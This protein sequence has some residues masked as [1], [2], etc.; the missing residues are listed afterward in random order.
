MDA[1]MDDLRVDF[2][3]FFCLISNRMNRLT[4]LTDVVEVV[5]AVVEEPVPVA[6]TAEA[7]RSGGAV[8][9]V[10]DAEPVWT[11]RQVVVD[12]HIFI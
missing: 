6:V 10:D 9:L 5:G 2:W 1:R 11:L 12:D 3:R 4:E 8:P 7:Q